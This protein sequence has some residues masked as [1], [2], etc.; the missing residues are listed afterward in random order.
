MQLDSR[1]L[2]AESQAWSGLVDDHNISRTSDETTFSITWCQ[3]SL[4]F[5]PC[6]HI[7]AMIMTGTGAGTDPQG[8]ERNQFIAFR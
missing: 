2:K 1:Q 7:I 3:W 4:K 8:A 6:D 5:P